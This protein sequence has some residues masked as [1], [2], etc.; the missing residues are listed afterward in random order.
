[1][2]RGEKSLHFRRQRSVIVARELLRQATARLAEFCHFLLNYLGRR[3][4]FGGVIY[5]PPGL[6]L[7]R[8]NRAVASGLWIAI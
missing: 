4:R 7:V 1:M 6:C 8:G 2:D 5:A 3:L